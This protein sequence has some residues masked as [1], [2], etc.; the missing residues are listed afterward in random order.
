MSLVIKSLNK[1]GRVVFKRFGEFASD[2]ES[3]EN[4]SMTPGK[5]FSGFLLS[6]FLANLFIDSTIIDADVVIESG[7]D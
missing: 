1:V 6:S 2:V 5:S 7:H 4:I 3:M